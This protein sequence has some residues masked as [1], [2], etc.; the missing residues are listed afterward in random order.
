LQIKK[1]LVVGLGSMGTGIAQVAAQSGF[2]VAAVDVDEALLARTTAIIE[3][4]LTKLVSK[5]KLTAEARE[6]AW[7]NLKMTTCLEEAALDCDL[8]VE[9]VFENLELKQELFG[10]LDVY[11]PKEAILASNTSSLPVTSLAAATRRPGQVIGMHFMNPVPLMRG[12]EL[13]KGRLTSAT[14]LAAAREFVEKLGKVPVEALDYPG[15]VVSRVLDVM[16]N[17]A[18]YCVMEGNKPE[19]IDKGMKECTN[20]PMGPL[21]LIDLAGADIL[22]NVMDLLH[23]ELGDKYRAAPLLRQMVRAGHCGRKSGRGFYDYTKK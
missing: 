15:F 9:A 19:E 22:L 10:K 6:A 4:S 3:A 21:E 14:T 2:Q 13:I 1:V 7:K 5:H 18:V 8:A 20:M 16:M 17:E 12:V 23:R 11:C